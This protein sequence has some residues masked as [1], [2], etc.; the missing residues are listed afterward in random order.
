MEEPPRPRGLRRRRSPWRRL[1]FRRLFYPQLARIVAGRLLARDRDRRVFVSM[2]G[3]V[4]D[5]VLLGPTLE[6]LAERYA[7]DFGAAGEPYLG[8]VRSSP[9]VSRIFSPFIYH[10]K[11]PAHR[12]L[13]E[14]LLGPFYARVALL[15]FADDDYWKAGVHVSRL[16]AERCGCPPP[17]HGRVDLADRHRAVADAYLRSARFADFVFVAQV[18]RDRQPFRSWPLEHHRALYRRLRTELGATV[19]ACTAGSDHVELPPDVVRLPPME[20]LAVAAVI[21]RA[22]LYV[23]PDGGLTHIAAAVGTPTVAIHLGYPPEVCGALGENVTLVR[24][25]RPFADPAATTPDEVFRA[26]TGALV[27]S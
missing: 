1:V 6:H 18:I 22:R 8:L 17:D 12:R 24:Q 9:F 20:L 4:G 15:E 19:V 5:L 3:G 10:P 25:S 13:I 26:I 23:G 11:R 2:M 27:A 14:R 21:E 16:F 7:I